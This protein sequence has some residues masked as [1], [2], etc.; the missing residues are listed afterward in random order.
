M[1]I[2]PPSRFFPPAEEAGPEGLVG[3]SSDLSP[4]RLLDAYRHGI[5]PWPMGN[6]D[7]LVPW[8]SPDP[9]AIIPLDAFHVPRRLWRTVHSGRF[10]ATADR[11]FPEV[12]RRCA[13]VRRPQEGTWLTPGM[14][15]AYGRLHELGFAHSVEVWCEGQLAG[16]VYGVALG[17]M[18]AGESMFHAE[19]DASKVALVHLV[20]HLCRRGYTLFDIQQW[21]PHTG[22]F[23]AV[24]MDRRRFLRR[25]ATALEQPVSFGEA[26]V[27]EEPPDHSIARCCSAFRTI[28]PEASRSRQR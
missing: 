26:T 10:T 28:S 27:L 6:V 20:C 19:R 18:F 5:F 2:L 16:G 22:Q 14:R 23:G 13:Q 17:G 8:W 25:L 24:E 11:C 4:E 1:P 9:R 12:I 21:T 3:L 15:R 7:D